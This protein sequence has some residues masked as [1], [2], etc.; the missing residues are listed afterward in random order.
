MKCQIVQCTDRDF[1]GAAP[2]FGR[3]EFVMATWTKLWASIG[4]I[5]GVGRESGCCLMTWTIRYSCN[6]GTDR[7][8]LDEH[9]PTHDEAR[10][11]EWSRM[12]QIA[13]NKPLSVVVKMRIKQPRNFNFACF[14]NGIHEPSIQL[15][16][17][18]SNRNWD[19][20]D[21]WW[22]HDK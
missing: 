14:C 6:A 4:N 17:Q 5:W 10:C 3:D 2:C 1:C 11:L 15:K 16:I 20:I 18:V 7:S 19:R 21:F 8:L 12:E 9:T 13:T 22:L